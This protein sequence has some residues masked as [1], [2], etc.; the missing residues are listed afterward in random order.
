VTARPVHR[1]TVS[2]GNL[3]GLPL[4]EPDGGEATC[5]PALVTCGNCQQAAGL[6]LV[7][8]RPAAVAGLPGEA[9]R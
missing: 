3:C 4:D 6:T 7:L 1:L 8:P 9:A 5:N 2:L